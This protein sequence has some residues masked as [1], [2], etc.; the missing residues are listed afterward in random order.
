MLL[1]AGGGA[2]GAVEGFYDGCFGADG[3]LLQGTE[4]KSALCR[5]LREGE[6]KGGRRGRILEALRVLDG[7]GTEGGMAVC[8]YSRCGV[9]EFTKEHVW[10]V[11][12]GARGAMQGDLQNVRAAERGMNEARGRRDFD[13][14]QGREGAVETN[15]CWMTWNA[16]EPPDES[17]GDVART[18]LYMA[19]R[20]GEGEDGLELVEATGTGGRRLGRLSTLLEWNELDPPDEAERWRNELVAGRFGGC[21]NPFVDHPEWA[22]TVF[23]EEEKERTKSRARDGSGGGE[24]TVTGLEARQ[25]YPWNGL[26]DVDYVVEGVEDGAGVAVAVR[27]MDGESG[28]AVEMRS[29]SGDGAAGPVRAGARRLTWDLGADA[30]GLVSDAFAVEMSAWLAGGMYLVVDLSC[31][32]EAESWPVERLDG[33]PEGGWTE[34]YKTSKLVLRRI[35]AGSFSMGS[36]EGE[37]GRHLDERAHEV[38]LSEAFYVG[39]FEVTQAQWELA[40]GG[41]PAFHEGALRPVDRVSYEMVRGAEAGNGWPANRGV[42]P[43]SFMGVLRAKTGLAF[44]L[45]TEA[46]WEYAC[47]A[48]TGTALNSGKDV[49]AWWS[50][51]LAE[52]GRYCYNGGL[53]ASD[54]KG[55]YASAHTTVG[56]YAPNAWGLYDMHG[57][58]W[59]WCLDWYGPYEGGVAVDPAGASKGV[60][61]VIRGGC[62]YGQARDC[63]SATR[64]DRG[65]GYERCGGGFRVACAAG[66]D[67]DGGMAEWTDRVELSGWLGAE[68]A[69]WA[70]GEAEWRVASGPGAIQDGVLEF[71]GMGEVV[72]EGTLPGGS[73]VADCAVSRTVTVGKASARVSFEGVA[74]QESGRV[75]AWGV[76]TEPAGLAVEVRYD[77]AGTEAPQEAGWHSVTAEVVDGRYRGRAEGTLVVVEPGRYLVVDLSGGQEAESW[78]WEVLEGMPEGGWG[79]EHKTSKLVLRWVEPGT[80]WMGCPEDEPGYHMNQTMDEVTLRENQTLHEVTL[81]KGYWIGVF[82]ITQKQAA[83]AAGRESAW[84]VGD[85]LPEHTISYD[86]IRG[87]SAGAGWPRNDMVDEGSVLWALRTKTGLPFDLPTEAE[88]EYACRAGTETALN[89]GKKLNGTSWQEPNVEEVGCYRYN[90]GYG[91]F[92]TGIIEGSPAPAGSY[93]PNAWGLYDMHGNVWEWCLDWYGQYPTEAVTNPLGPVEGVVRMRRGGGWNCT[94]TSVRSACRSALAPSYRWIWESGFRVVCHEA[95]EEGERP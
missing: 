2:F 43:E 91:G 79:E 51:N 25:R 33:E 85:M 8:V 41:N 71:T 74:V 28:E 67:G 61:R 81:T 78:P 65:A 36:P 27:G 94:A 76:R 57:N 22:R 49:G 11:S 86:E 60:S 58:V 52:I 21:R 13:W 10:P 12:H 44:D 16:W 42:D 64:H 23:G 48:G 26:V 92:Y 56:S 4:L 75:A 29:L 46:Q 39:V 62:W 95:E 73:G 14:C 93:L 9:E 50:S 34:E 59:E 55:E 35:L 66:A 19:V 38:T 30:P 68:W 32:R 5:V 53:L 7:D 47:R 6:E 24:L 20:Y 82:E 70:G 18:A 87:A 90:S 77:G 15:G 31:G 54:G 80:F 88:W 1:G 72:V 84:F 63:R 69:D 40:M 45:P 3:R 37:A 89:S 17:K 83:L